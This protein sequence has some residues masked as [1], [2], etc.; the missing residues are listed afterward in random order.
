MELR[1]INIKA[2]PVAANTTP[3]SRPSWI[4]LAPGYSKFNGDA[5]I[6]RHGFGSIGVIARDQ[7]GTFLG[8]S[9]LVF[10]FISNPPTL[11]AL[12]IREALALANDLCT[13][14]VQV[15]SD[16]KVVVD[17]IQKRNLSC[18]GAIVHEIRD[19]SSSF[20]SCNIVY[21]SRSSNF[22]AHNLAKHALTLGGGHH[23]WL[24]HPGN[25]L[26]VPVNIVTN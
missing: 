2:S 20:I 26:S 8:A 5:A 19:M 17:D 14:H 12:A 22:E 6:S 23:V 16:C 1:E 21:E 25:L 18:Y 3:Q 9:A 15:A 4:P 10:R 24:G 11:E 13:Q 7:G